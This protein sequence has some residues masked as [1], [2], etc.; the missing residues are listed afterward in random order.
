MPV[1]EN[2]TNYLR[3]KQQMRQLVAAAKANATPQVAKNVKQL[4]YAFPWMT[5]GTTVALAQSG[6]TL[7]QASEVAYLDLQKQMQSYT[8]SYDMHNFE[9]PQ[10]KL[11]AAYDELSS[12]IAAQ[13]R[14]AAGTNQAQAALLANAKKDFDTQRPGVGAIDYLQTPGQN[15]VP[16]ANQGRDFNANNSRALHYGTTDITTLYA[17]RALVA[18]AA[19]SDDPAIQQG[20][21]NQIRAIRKGGPQPTGAAQALAA[22]TRGA[23]V[24][25]ESLWQGT[26]G[27]LRMGNVTAQ[28]ETGLMAAGAEKTGNALGVS[29]GLPNV[30]IGPTDRQSKAIAEANKKYGVFGP[31]MA[32]A[33][34]TSLGQVAIAAA[35]GRD[36]DLGTG[37]FVNPESGIAKAQAA[38]ARKYSPYLIGG[39]AWTPGREIANNASLETDS[40][41]FQILSG[42]V[43]GGLMIVADPAN[44]ALAKIG[45]WNRARKL[46][47]T[48]GG[49]ED[50]V[51]AIEL[52]P[53]T[54]PGATRA[55]AAIDMPPPGVIPDDWVP[56]YK[57][58]HEGDLADYRRTQFLQGGMGTRRYPSFITD[59]ENLAVSV[60]NQFNEAAR[61]PY[62][63]VRQGLRIPYGTGVVERIMVPPDY[64][65]RLQIAQRLERFREFADDF[66]IAPL[67]NDAVDNG[68]GVVL[69]GYEFTPEEWVIGLRREAAGLPA[70]GV[71]T[72]PLSTPL[73]ATDF[74]G[75]QYRDVDAAFFEGAITAADTAHYGPWLN[76]DHPSRWAENPIVNVFRNDPATP[77]VDAVTDGIYIYPN[78]EIARR[79]GAIEFRPVT[80]N[81]GVFGGTQTPVRVSDLARYNDPVDVYNIPAAYE[82]G[83]RSIHGTRT[84]WQNNLPRRNTETLGALSEEWGNLFGPGLYTTADDAELGVTLGYRGFG[85]TQPL[86]PGAPRG[87]QYS[88]TWHGQEPP[89]VL[90]LD[91][92]SF[93]KY[94]ERAYPEA[95]I[96]D[97]ADMWRGHTD[98][99]ASRLV[100]W[101]DAR[102]RDEFIANA[103][104]VDYRTSRAQEVINSEVAIF[105]DLIDG[106]ITGQT[107]PGEFYKYVVDNLGRSRGGYD[108]GST[109]FAQDLL[110]DLLQRNYDALGHEGGAIT[111]TDAHEVTIWLN[112]ENLRAARIVGSEDLRLDPDPFDNVPFFVDNTIKSKKD[113][114]REAGGGRGRRTLIR[115]KNPVTWMYGRGSKIVKAIADTASA[116]DIYW[117]LGEKIPIQSATGQNVLRELAAATT[118]SEVRIILSRELGTSIERVPKWKN[119][120]EVGTRLW[121]D[122]PRGAMRWD[123]PDRNV[124]TLVDYMTL[125]KFDLD[126]QERLFNQLVE[127]HGRGDQFAFM[128]T[129]LDTLG[130]QLKNKGADAEWVDG[131][132]RTSKEDWANSSKWGIDRDTGEDVPLRL[133][134]HRTDPDQLPFDIPQEVLDIFGPRW[135]NERLNST[136]YLPDPDAV[137]RMVANPLWRDMVNAGFNVGEYGKIRP[138]SVLMGMADFGNDAWKS[139]TLMRVAWPIRVV[140]EELIRLAV[141]GDGP[142]TSPLSYIALVMGNP[143][144]YIDDPWYIKQIAKLGERESAEIAKIVE[145]TVDP[146]EIRRLMGE[147]MAYDDAMAAAEKTA[148]DNI[149]PTWQTKLAERLLEWRNSL[150]TYQTNIAGRRFD[151][152]DLYAD[153]LSRRALMTMGDKTLYL[154]HFDSVARAGAG[155]EYWARGLV[156]ELGMAHREPVVQ[157]ALRLS[158]DE[159]LEGL[160]SENWGRSAREQMAAGRDPANPNEAAWLRVRDD[161]AVSDAYGR[162]VLKEL[163]ELHRG[164]ETLIEA[165]RT[166]RLEGERLA[167]NGNGAVQPNPKAVKIAEGYQ[168]AGAGPDFVKVQRAIIRTWKNSEEDSRQLRT[169]IAA[170]FDMLGTKPSNYLTRSPHFRLTYWDEIEK[171]LP[172]LDARGQQ[173]L[174]DNLDLANLPQAKAARLRSAVRRNDAGTLTWTQVDLLASQRSLDNVREV[175]YDL[176]KKSQFFDAMR[177]VMPFG[178]AWREMLVTWAR[179]ARDY[180]QV[181]NRAQQTLSGIREAPANPITGLP[182]GMPNLDAEGNYIGGKPT[183]FFRFDPR[184]DS[185]VFTYPLTAWL[186]KVFGS[187]LPTP[188]I[189]RTAGLSMITTGLPGIGPAVQL[190]VSELLRNKPQFDSL[191]EILFPFGEPQGSDFSERLTYAVSPNWFKKFSQASADPRT[192]PQFGNLV[193]DVMAVLSSTGEYKIAGARDPNDPTAASEADR[194]LKDSISQARWLSVVATMGSFVMPS[195]PSFDMYVKKNQSKPGGDKLVLLQQLRDD[196]RR[197]V[198]KFGADEGQSQFVKTYGVD[199]IFARV[200]K[201]ELN[202]AGLEATKAQRDWERANS[203]IV[204]QFPKTWALFAPGGKESDFNLDVYQLQRDAG[205][206]DWSN[207]QNVQQ[208]GIAIRAEAAWDAVR[209]QTG[210]DRP[211]RQQLAQRA[212]AKK[213]LQKWYPGWTGVYT[214]ADEQAARL[215]EL[216]RAA[217]EP[218]TR[219]TP[220]ATAL[221]EYFMLRDSINVAA[222]QYSDKSTSVFNSRETALARSSLLGQVDVLR[223]QNKNFSRAWDEVLKYEFGDL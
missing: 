210:G 199:N 121:R 122:M 98:E 34:Q 55:G 70:F 107:A 101:W 39:H 50:T 67:V 105:E 128:D 113:L 86:E 108:S 10:E 203:E 82:N 111:G 103:L 54:V 44:I 66:D 160:W 180:P 6:A 143:N 167:V 149:P 165:I 142:F 221:R 168:Q 24:G 89:K 16:W 52:A 175:L 131:F 154:N 8:Q 102:G 200:P 23:S 182:T 134:V 193:T 38:A 139:L 36:I 141:V 138:W 137:R 144:R 202:V 27:L 222:L 9:K 41:P 49:A 153:A 216:E 115:S 117:A 106:V 188:M 194:L 176:H 32:I 51:R 37:F 158:E 136:F 120:A 53:E 64:F 99:F 3:W 186:S 184:T 100:D 45:Q 171:L 110:R 166:G 19:N 78:E 59:D 197:M 157:Q 132:I 217:E 213:Q 1:Y 81:E 47:E 223:T 69:N 192:D 13:E 30:E 146:E 133:E 183:G 33:E 207:T 163:E 60:A 151:L 150:G 20:A 123:S 97:I 179:L 209:A 58:S 28:V 17:L 119:G 96:E 159:F 29:G 56:A 5:P 205:Y 181:T 185:E 26:V 129:L 21:L 148:R 177:L 201:S 43:D 198:N 63:N 112:Q 174:L 22:T 173:V 155:S 2:Q 18:T 156:G 95:S 124:Q 145:Q 83:P 61:T 15:D 126:T 164:D 77:T 94:A 35:E 204:A 212:V 135:Q 80:V 114:L 7:E 195:A 88:I 208:R 215:A 85:A 75:R 87:A 74:V 73:D 25:L 191:K 214:G 4:M 90:F 147:G 93:K 220:F 187:P 109:V 190:P 40:I 170:L 68:A 57:F 118:E 116:W 62:E 31:Y 152:N 91:K 189:G 84:V 71:R 92:W 211:T 130:E 219:D 65:D 218:L 127:A 11:I 14:Q 72:T 42:L 125:S 161:R 76:Q 162:A 196:Y 169:V 178:E 79:N 140:G 12:Y 48:V 46:F 104:N 172:A 206:R